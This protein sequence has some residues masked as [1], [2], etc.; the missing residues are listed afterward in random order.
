MTSNLYEA[1]T[2]KVRS[3]LEGTAVLTAVVDNLG[4]SE[5][6][7]LSDVTFGIIFIVLSDSDSSSVA[8]W[9]SRLAVEHVSL[10]PYQTPIDVLI[11]NRDDGH[12][13]SGR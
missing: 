11:V 13:E 4:S 2:Q 9:P 12:I 3:G 6:R 8:C 5:A 10:L 7:Y 1:V